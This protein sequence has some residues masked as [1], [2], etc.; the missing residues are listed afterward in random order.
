VVDVDL[1]K[2]GDLKERAVLL[3]DGVVLE[4]WWWEDVWEEG[5]VGVFDEG[6]DKW[7]DLGELGGLL[8][9]RGLAEDDEGA[10]LNVWVWG[11]A[12]VKG[13]SF[14]VKGYVFCVT[15]CILTIFETNIVMNGNWITG[16]TSR[17][18]LDLVQNLHMIIECFA[19]RSVMSWRRF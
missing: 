4:R 16:W 9:W 14:I 6:V 5:I 8:G 3:G 7:E 1:D 11:L 13:Y 2:R 12:A 10:F 17:M 18:M 15:I 19:N